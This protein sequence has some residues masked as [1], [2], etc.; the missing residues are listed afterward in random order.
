MYYSNKNTN[1][2]T[3]V[4]K[5]ATMLIK[6]YPDVMIIQMHGKVPWHASIKAVYFDVRHAI[7]RSRVQNE[8]H[9]LHQAGKA[10]GEIVQEI[11]STDPGLKKRMSSSMI[12]RIEMHL[13][14]LMSYT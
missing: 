3:Y 8:L 7:L 9:L 14:K 10:P 1:V 2:R 12:Q 5:I 4:L 6:M 11:L 13:T